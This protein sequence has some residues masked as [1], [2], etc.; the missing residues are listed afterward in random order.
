MNNNNGINHL[1]RVMQ[2]RVK[3]ITDTP[4]PID[5]ATVKSAD[6]IR[7]DSYELDIP[8]SD[9]ARMKGAPS[10][11]VGDRIVIAYVGDDILLLGVL[12]D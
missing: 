11:S 9:L 6:T 2:K 7:V 4:E 3:D 10:L 5:F 1:A 8:M 12:E